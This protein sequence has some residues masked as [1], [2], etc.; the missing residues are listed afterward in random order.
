M[1]IAIAIGPNSKII[2]H[3]ASFLNEKVR[4]FIAQETSGGFAEIAI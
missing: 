4:N 3:V 1:T 2:I